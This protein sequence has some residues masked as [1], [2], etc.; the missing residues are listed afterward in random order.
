MSF[1][2]TDTVDKRRGNFK[3]LNL[4]FNSLSPNFRFSIS[5]TNMRHNHVIFMYP[6]VHVYDVI[7]YKSN[8][9]RLQNKVETI[10]RDHGLP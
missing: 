8:Y 4:C 10:K 7:L 3:D 6:V 1:P 2:Q 5:V 9:S